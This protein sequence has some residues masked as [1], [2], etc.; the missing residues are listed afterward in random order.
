MIPKIGDLIIHRYGFYRGPGLVISCY[1]SPVNLS[2]IYDVL[3]GD[4]LEKWEE[5]FIVNWCEK[6]T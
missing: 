4:N 1:Y 6:L 3:V 5:S 2:R